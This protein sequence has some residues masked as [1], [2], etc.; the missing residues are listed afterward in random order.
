VS[1]LTATQPVE[2]LAAGRQPSRRVPQLDGLRGIAIFLVLIWHYGVNNFDYVEGTLAPNSIAAY[3]WACLSLGWSG[4]DLFF[5]LS[6]FLIGGILMD[7]RQA[8]NFFQVFYVRRVCRIFPLYFLWLLL[9]C[10]VIWAA[11]R[12]LLPT[13][14]NALVADPLPLWSYATF[15][16]NLV[17]AY[18]NVFGPNWMGITWSLAVEEQFYCTLPFVIRYV[19]PR[20]LPWVLGGFILA[21]PLLRVAISFWFESGPLA[22]YVLTPCRA[23][24]LLLG[25]LCAWMVRQPH[26]SRLLAQHVAALYAVFVVLLAGTVALAVNYNPLISYGWP[27]LGYTWLALFYT[28]FLLISVT[29][30]RGVVKAIAMNVVLRRL[31][32]IAYGV[33]LFHVAI[34]GLA[35]GLI[36]HQGPII[37]NARDLM[38]TALALALTVALAQ[39]SWN[40]FEK[41]LVDLGHRLRYRAAQL[42]AKAW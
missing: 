5:V 25:A 2:S 34:L 33:Y 1:A 39:L 4:V 32:L 31:G 9:F 11:Y 28:C 24:A 6:G 41:P 35:H 17:M 36:A 21:A 12:L 38:V 42:A 40:M 10:G 27:N 16:Q 14:L 13:S 19:E 7:N 23:D 3:A 30:K 20:K 29:E 37:R 15:T 26:V 18:R 22:A 8:D